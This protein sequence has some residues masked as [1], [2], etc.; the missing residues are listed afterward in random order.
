MIFIAIVFFIIFIPVASVEAVEIE[1]PINTYV[2][3]NKNSDSIKIETNKY[4]FT[5]IYNNKEKKLDDLLLSF[6]VS[7]P[8][9]INADKYKIMIVDSSHQCSDNNILVK[10]KIDLTMINQGEIIENNTF[11]HVEINDRW[12]EH[13]LSL[14]FPIINTI[15]EPQH[16]SGRVTLNVGLQ[17]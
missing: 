8:K 3:N 16:C 17:V 11:K 10:T 2:I 1:I 13:T 6:K 9:D 14:E 5:T 7:S 4:S 15:N 12:S